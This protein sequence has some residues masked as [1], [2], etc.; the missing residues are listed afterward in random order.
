M[1]HTRKGIES[2]NLSLSAS[3]CQGPPPE[4]LEIGGTDDEAAVVFDGEEAPSFPNVPDA[5]TSLPR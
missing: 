4:H 1:R 5:Y 2:S 3:I